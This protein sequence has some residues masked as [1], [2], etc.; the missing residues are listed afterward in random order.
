[1][2]PSVPK[3]TR[4]I[5][6]ANPPIGEV[7]ADTF[8][9]EEWPLAEL[10]DGEVLLKMLAFGNEPAQRCWM[11]GNTDPRRLYVEPVKQGD[12]VRAFGIG[13][14]LVS[15]S[16]KWEVGQRVTGVFVWQEYLVVNEGG[17]NGEAA[18]IPGMSEWIWLGIFGL[19][20]LTAWAGATKEC[21]LKPEHTVLVSG[22][23]GAVG[24]VFVQIAKKVIGCKKVVGVAG[25]REKCDWVKSLGA[26][27]CVDYKSKSFKKDLQAALPDYAD[28]FFDLA[29]G[30]VLD[31][32]L[33]VVARHGFISQCGALDIY[34]GKPLELTNYREV[35]YNRLTIKGFIIIDHMG[36]I[37]EATGDLG[38]WVQEGKIS[39]TG[40]ET[41]VDTKF[42]DV[43][44]TWQMLFSGAT[45]G[46]L[47]T[48]LV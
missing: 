26:D 7:Q 29:G 18:V 19:N 43:P 42:E 20:G 46:K 3:T 32:A 33:T 25:G 12:A 34:N 47:I 4:T 6:L 22:A 2:T 5:V 23:A 14:I 35:I 48:K 13:E 21:N 10:K 36:S 8:K 24:S 37:A 11:D 39:F 30:K 1:M 45:R 27:D 17:I 9:L 15:K 41:V 31:V 44:K 40:G 16:D 38:K 28:V